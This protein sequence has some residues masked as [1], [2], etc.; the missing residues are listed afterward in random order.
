M[1]ELKEVL[2]TASE[3][4][5]GTERDAEINACQTLLRESQVVGE[6]E[7]GNVYILRYAGDGKLYALGNYNRG[8]LV[9]ISTYE[10]YIAEHQEDD[11]AW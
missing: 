11:G 1:R 2:K 9:Y 5:D 4:Y 10:E 7:G 8:H 6:L 3:C